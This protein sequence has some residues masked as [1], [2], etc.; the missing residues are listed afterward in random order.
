MRQARYFGRTKTLFQLLMAATV[1][2]LTLVAGKVGK[3]GPPSRGLGAWLGKGGPIFPLRKGRQVVFGPQRYSAA[4]LSRKMLPTPSPS[5]RA[6]GPWRPSRASRRG[7][8]MG[9]G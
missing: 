5:C 1:A 9:A 7:S 6:F 3:I 2:N 4:D 8:M